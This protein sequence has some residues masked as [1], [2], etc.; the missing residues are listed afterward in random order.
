MEFFIQIF[1]QL[2]PFWPKVMVLLAIAALLLLP[3]ARSL[4]RQASTGNR[5]LARAK[6][7]LEVRKLQ[8]DVETLRAKNPD[9][10]PSVLDPPIKKLLAVVVEAEDEEEARPLEWKERARFALRGAAVLFVVSLLTLGLTGRRT[11]VELL[12]VGFWELVVLLPCGLLAAT[13]PSSSR[14][15]SILYGFLLPAVVASIAVAARLRG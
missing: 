2:P 11:G 4:F 13:I 8:L 5:R 6:S 15:S 3:G 9:A 1:K 14:W 12:Q 7:L 10:A